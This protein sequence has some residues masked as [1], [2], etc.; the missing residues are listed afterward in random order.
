MIGIDGIP[1]AGVGG[2]IRTGVEA[3]QDIFTVFL[4]LGTLVGVVV[5]GYMLYNAIKYRAGKD[6]DPEKEPEGFELG[7]LPKGSGGGRKLL[8]SFSLS[9]I[10]VVGLVFWTYGTLLYLDDGPSVS[11]ENRM[12]IRVEGF[13]FGW[14]FIYENGKET[15]TLRVPEGEVIWLE[16]TST[17]V[18]H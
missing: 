13:Q 8:L 4:I 16:V 6:R 14:T 9:A 12:D 17:D 1:L 11:P 10:I 5:I 15:S 2:S 7:E 18:F 3:F